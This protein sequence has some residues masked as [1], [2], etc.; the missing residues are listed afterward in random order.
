MLFSTEFLAELFPET[1]GLVENGLAINQVTTD[2][3]HLTDQSLFIPLKGDSFDGHKFLKGAID[4]G[5]VATLWQK[6]M[7]LPAFIPDEFVVFYV[8]DTLKALQQLAHQYRKLVNP[9]VIGV[10]GSNGKTTTKDLV[11]S[12]LQTTFVTHRTKGNFNNHIGLP[13]TILSMTRDTEV[14]VLEMGMN[15]FGEIEL[16]SK[17][18][19]PDYAIITNIGESHIEFL[20]SREGI[21]EAKSEIIVGLKPEGQLLID[22]DEPLLDELKKQE[23]VISIGFDTENNIT[24]N[25]FSMSANYSSFELN[26]GKL[27]QLSML[28]QHNVKNATFAIEIAKYLKIPEKLIKDALLKLDLTGMRFE[29]KNG[30]NGVTIINDAYNASPTSM[31]ASIDVVKQMKDYSSKVLV[32]GDMYEMGNNSRKMHRSVAEI[33][34]E[35]IDFVFTIGNDSKE[36]SSAVASQSDLIVTKHFQAKDELAK[37]LKEH[38]NKDTIILLKASRGVRLETILDSLID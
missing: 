15:H 6:D 8:E 4:N 37:H 11:G 35:D 32:L 22:G 33:I 7:E 29:L 23:N 16:L 14:L 27:F 10:T 26:N 2:S 25:N 13:L 20:G 30:I 12:V 31:K 36:I 24:I 1:R 19:M 18:A 34:T 28:G 21:A 17:I 38:L 3:R 5:A 9:V